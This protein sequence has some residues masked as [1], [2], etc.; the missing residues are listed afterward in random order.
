M[1]LTLKLRRQGLRAPAPFAMSLAAMFS[2][3]SMHW[4][5]G[6]TVMSREVMRLPA[7]LVFGAVP[8]LGSTSGWATLSLS[9]D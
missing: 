1:R 8:I 2:Q 3:P 7:R 6:I 9:R 4:R 5:Q